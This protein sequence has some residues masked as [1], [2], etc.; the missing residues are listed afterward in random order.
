MT[1][2][3]FGISGFRIFAYKVF[4][5][6]TTSV[7][8]TVIDQRHSSGPRAPEL[9][10]EIYMIMSSI[11]TWYYTFFTVFKDAFCTIITSVL[12]IT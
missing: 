9:P 1:F 5:A 11:F 7:K 6:P 12:L 3:T 2:K 8:R 4:L 10:S